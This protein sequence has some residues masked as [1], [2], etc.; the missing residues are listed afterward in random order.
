MPEL[1]RRRHKIL[2]LELHMGVSNPMWVLGSGLLQE[3]CVPLTAEPCL[4]S[5]SQ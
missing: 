1:S 3:L 2:E 5:S 4:S